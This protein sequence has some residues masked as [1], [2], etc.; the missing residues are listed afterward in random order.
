MKETLTAIQNK[1]TAII[2][3]LYT[4][5]QSGQLTGRSVAWSLSLSV[6]FIVF[7]FN[8]VILPIGK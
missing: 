3:N 5:D 1:Q 7:L 8:F 6:Y 2:R 4:S